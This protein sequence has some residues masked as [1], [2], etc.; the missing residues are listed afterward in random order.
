MNVEDA[1]RDID[2]LVG[3]HKHAGDSHALKD[4]ERLLDLVTGTTHVDEKKLQVKVAAVAFY[5]DN[6][7]ERRQ[8]LVT[9]VQRLKIALQPWDHLRSSNS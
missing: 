9:A 8:D 7:Y 3:S 4:F 2:W 6:D 1:V 5:G